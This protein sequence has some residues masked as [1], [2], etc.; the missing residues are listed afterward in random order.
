MKPSI[1]RTVNDD[2]EYERF[3]Q[4]FAAHRD[5]LFAYVYSLLPHHADAEDVFQRCSLLLWRKFD[6]FERDGS[7]LAWGC[8]VAFYEVKNFLRSANRN[9]LQ[10]DAD[11]VSQIAEQRLAKSLELSPKLEALAGCVE[12]LKASDRELIHHAYHD[13]EGLKVHAATSGKAIQTLYNRLSIL[14]RQLMECVHRKLSLE[15]LP[16]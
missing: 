6:Q 8:G 9:R 13:D 14:R 12:N 15:G 2:Q 11:L 5:R 7:F 16:S 3:L 10:F 1:I 4:L